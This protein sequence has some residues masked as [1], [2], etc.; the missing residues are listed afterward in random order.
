MI[1]RKQNLDIK[2]AMDRENMDQ[3]INQLKL[4]EDDKLK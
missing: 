1:N 4:R 3:A 2:R